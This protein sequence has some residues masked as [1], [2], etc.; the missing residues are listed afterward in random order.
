MRFQFFTTPS[1][2]QMQD[3]TMAAQDV[4]RRNLMF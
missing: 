1:K 2:T 3:L 4:P